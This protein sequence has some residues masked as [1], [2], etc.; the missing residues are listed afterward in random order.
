MVLDERQTVIVLA[1]DVTEQVRA[2]RE[3]QVMLDVIQS[4]NL[5][6]D[7]DD[8]LQL[9]HASLKR[10]LYAENCYVALYNKE[11]KLFELP[12]VV[13]ATGPV[14]AAQDLGKSCAAYVFRTGEPLLITPDVFK[15][16]V[17][18]G[19]IELVGTDSSS[20]LGVPLRTPAET[21]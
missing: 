5:T 6:A 8:L 7:L 12:F 1:T 4:V 9:I 3:R 10:V 17:E 14:P 13:D 18:E 11:T 20:W 15:R 2:E 16:L 21:I 19:E